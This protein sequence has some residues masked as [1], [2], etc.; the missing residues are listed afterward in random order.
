[1]V[2]ELV[3][4]FLSSTNP[5][6]GV[7]AKRDGIHL[8]L[9]SKSSDREQAESLINKREND[10]RA[11]LKDSVW[12]T[13]SNT[14]ETIIAEL[15]A[16]KRLT[17]ATMECETGGL[18]AQTITSV[19]GSSA[20]YKGGLIACTDEAKTGMGI[21]ASLISRYTS[22][23]IE[24]AEAMATKAREQFDADI[25]IGLTVAVEPTNIKDIPVGS[26]FLSIVDGTTKHRSLRHAPGQQ[27]QLKQRAVI[28]TLFELRKILL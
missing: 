17:L 12:G 6:M 19:P 21:D 1:M 23:S 9:T 14:L 11:I 25:G 24:M 27:H 5:T 26:T 18:L 4:P 8:R 13:D 2:D 3:S 20:Y 15:L 10:I 16:K 22:A 28:S 7:Y